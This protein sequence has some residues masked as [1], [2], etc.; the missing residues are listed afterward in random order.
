M[1]DSDRRYSDLMRRDHHE[2][3]WLRSF[4]F[5][6]PIALVVQCRSPAPEPRPE[7]VDE[8]AHDPRDFG[9]V[10]M[11]VLRSAEKRLATRLAE[12]QIDVSGRFVRFRELTA[13]KYNN[14]L[15]GMPRSIHALDGQTV[16]IVGFM[17]PIDRYDDMTE[18]ILVE[19]LIEACFGDPPKT[20]GCVWVRLI[21]VTQ[22]T[23]RDPLRVEGTFR[24]RPTFEEGMCVNIFEI[25]GA[26][27]SKVR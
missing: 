27:V 1:P 6:A 3:A 14:A 12:N 26:L 8:Y 11:S 2:R 7:P 24:V 16:T 10:P 18:F 15:A 19:S 9:S 4:W 5:A 25:Q 22:Y 21:G 23:D 17:L 13:W 20:N